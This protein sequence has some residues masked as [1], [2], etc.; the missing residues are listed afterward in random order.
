MRKEM[1]A[2]VL[3]SL[4]L[5]ITTWTG[6]ACEGKEANNSSQSISAE[7][8]LKSASESPVDNTDKTDVPSTTKVTGA[9][10]FEAEDFS[11]E[12]KFED[13]DVFSINYP[14]FTSQAYSEYQDDFNSLLKQYAY[15]YW[16]FPEEGI[17]YSV[18]FEIT[19]YNVHWISIL[20]SLRVDRTDNIQKHSLNLSLNSGNINRLM[21]AMED[22]V[23]WNASYIWDGEEECKIVS[24]GIINSALSEYLQSEYPDYDT[25]LNVFSNADNTDFLSDYGTCWTYFSDEGII[26]LIP[27]SDEMGNY[28]EVKMVIGG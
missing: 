16:I 27:V 26:V 20:Y 3:C 21:D 2:G 9:T 19:G 13:G 1:V 17:H 18:S 24:E 8:R 6:A 11:I 4:L 10:T 7:T 23:D 22:G 15:N 12:N 25:F 5:F 28:V 14:V